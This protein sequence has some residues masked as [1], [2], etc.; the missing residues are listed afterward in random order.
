MHYTISQ[1][2]IRLLRDDVVVYTGELQ[3]LR[4]EKD[5]VREVRGG[6]E[7]GL[8]VKDFNDIKVGDELEFYDIKYVKRTLS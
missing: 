3:S 6:F 1:H 4:R 2:K 8:T 7:C 5:D